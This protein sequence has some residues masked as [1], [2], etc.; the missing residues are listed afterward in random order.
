MPPNK[1][2][3]SKAH[4]SLSQ[5]FQQRAIE[6]ARSGTLGTL[7]T[8]KASLQSSW[9]HLVSLIDAPEVPILFYGEK[10]SGKR[11][12]ID[13]FVLIQN[14]CR[15]IDGHPEAKI[16]VFVANFLNEGFSAQF[17]EPTLSS[18]DVVYLEAI[19]RLDQGGQEE[20]LAH[21]KLRRHLSQKGVL[22]PRLLLSTERA[23]SMLVLQKTFSRELFAAVTSIAIFLPSLNERPED[24]PH[25]LQSTAED[26]TGK[27]QLPKTWIVDLLSKQLWPENLDELQKTIRSMLA[28]NS[29]MSSWSSADLPP[30]MRARLPSNFTRV[31]SAKLAADARRRHLLQQALMA[32][33]GSRD[34]AAASVGLSKGEFLKQ[35]MALGLR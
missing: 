9:A 18:K 16:K 11:R 13:E 31:D 14:F 33:G 25:L 15:R 19:D 30:S 4:L 1:G 6:L 3:G 32:C 26:I 22:L 21:I 29:D 20:L 7:R 34:Q 35:L 24:F 28:R 27:K 23:L 8:R 17:L 10:G 5:R 12:T 2:Q